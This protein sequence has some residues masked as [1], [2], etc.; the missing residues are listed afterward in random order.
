M[1]SAWTPLDY[2]T[3]TSVNLCLGVA[4]DDP[5]PLPGTPPLLVLLQM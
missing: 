1:G 2:R 5:R 4:R 3:P